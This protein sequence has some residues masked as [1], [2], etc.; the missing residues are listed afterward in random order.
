MILILVCGRVSC[1]PLNIQSLSVL[2]GNKAD[3]P[4]SIGGTTGP[5]FGHEAANRSFVKAGSYSIFLLFVLSPGTMA[6]VPAAIM[7]SEG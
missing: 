5:I 2:S 3:C 4:A 7:K 1:L 6:G